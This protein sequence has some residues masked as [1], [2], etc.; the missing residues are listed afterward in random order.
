[1]NQCRSQSNCTFWCLQHSCLSF[2]FVARWEGTLL[3]LLLLLLLLVLRPQGYKSVTAGSYGRAPRG[4][5]A[6]HR[7]CSVALRVPFDRDRERSKALLLAVSV[8]LSST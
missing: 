3:L 5:H 4:T 2:N 1:M 7:L 6:L 8:W